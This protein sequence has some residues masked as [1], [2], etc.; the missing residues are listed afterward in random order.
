MPRS[1]GFRTAFELT[2]YEP[3]SYARD[4]VDDLLVRVVAVLYDNGTAVV[5]LRAS[6]QYR[7]TV[8][9]VTKANT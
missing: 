5:S 4:L 7:V 9:A 8:A 2:F 1:R 6:W 3:W